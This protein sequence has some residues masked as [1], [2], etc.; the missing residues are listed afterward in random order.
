MMT[1]RDVSN[2]GLPQ[3]KRYGERQLRNTRVGKRQQQRDT[4]HDPVDVRLQVDVPS[5]PGV[6]GK[7]GARLKKRRGL[8]GLR[9]LNHL[10]QINLARGLD[11]RRQY[12][13]VR[14]E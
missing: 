2:I 7:F 12:R 4:T 6:F 10:R 14:S 1:D 9:V 5:A 11:G 3:V 8:T 13:V